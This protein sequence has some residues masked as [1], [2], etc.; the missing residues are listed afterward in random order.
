MSH[1]MDALLADQRRIEADP[2]YIAPVV[3]DEDRIAQDRF[4]SLAGQ[5]S[6]V[7]RLMVQC[8]ELRAQVTEL[9]NV[10]TQQARRM[11]ELLADLATLKGENAT[12]D[13]GCTIQRVVLGDSSVMVEYDHGEAGEVRPMRALINGQW[14]AIG[15]VARALGEDALV[16]Q[17]ALWGGQ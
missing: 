8:G 9:E 10:A 17:I 4:V 16:E 5:D 14:S 1:L 7:A 3:A 6:R 13:R 15:D 2:A 11:G 12:P